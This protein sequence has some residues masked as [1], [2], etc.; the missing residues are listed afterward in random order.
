MARRFTYRRRR[1]RSLWPAALG[2]LA[3]LL[4]GLW[5]GLPWLVGWVARDQLEA[6][7]FP[8]PRLSVSSI[9]THEAK[10][11]SIA[12]GEAGELRA[13]EI[14]LAYAPMD[15]LARRIERVRI[16]GLRLDLDVSGDRPTFGTLEA[17]LRAMIEGEGGT[18]PVPPVELEKATLR[19]ETPLGIVDMPFHG[20]I[21]RNGD[22]FVAE[23]DLTATSE[24]GGLGGHLHARLAD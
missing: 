22:A 5:A 1:G 16:R 11:S 20:N 18:F 23:L 8:Q 4:V 12:L 24:H 7:G 3:L 2:V 19:L 17:P 9:G 10:V 6:L 21:G 15:L 13:E 14:V